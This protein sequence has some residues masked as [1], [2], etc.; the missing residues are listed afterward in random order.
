MLTTKYKHMLLVLLL[1]VL[2]TAPASAHIFLDSQNLGES[3]KEIQRSLRDLQEEE[4]DKPPILYQLGIQVEEL[5]ELL[6]T[7]VSVHGMEQQGLLQIAESRLDAMNI[8]VFWSPQHRQYFYDGAAFRSYLEYAPD[9]PHAAESLYRLLDYDFYHL[10]ADD[11]DSLRSAAERKR[12]FL[13]RFP[14]FRAAARIGF[15]IGI[16]YR[17]LWRLCRD[18]GDTECASHNLERSR[19]Q[20]SWLIEEYEDSDTAELARRLLD[21]INDEAADT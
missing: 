18:E 8:R 4:A 10:D 17:D 13:K 14:E 3:L 11:F 1:A 21:R 20:F 12:Q 16:D 15:Y 5:T 7:E 19:E 6:N 2:P 9:G